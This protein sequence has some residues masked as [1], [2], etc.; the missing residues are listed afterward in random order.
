MTSAP[1]VEEL[2]PVAADVTAVEEVQ[3]VLAGDQE[4]TLASK[5]ALEV[6]IV[7]LLTST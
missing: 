3:P 4:E 1:I 7:I 5:A 6:K 2:E